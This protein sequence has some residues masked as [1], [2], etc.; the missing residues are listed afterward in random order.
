MSKEV[1][2]VANKIE[3]YIFPDVVQIN[4]AENIGDVAL[5]LLVSL[6]AAKSSPMS[7]SEEDVHRE[8]TELANSGNWDELAFKGLQWIQELRP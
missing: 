6:M 5:L 2:Y 4:L 8:I 7:I 1:R 3:N